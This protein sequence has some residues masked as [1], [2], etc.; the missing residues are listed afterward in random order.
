[1]NVCMTKLRLIIC[2]LL[3]H[4][5]LSAQTAMKS[6]L[7]SLLNDGLLD[8]VDASVVIYDLDED[9]L[10]YAHR[11]NKLVRP[12]SV[13]KV[14]TSAVA[15]EKLGSDYTIDT[16]L[17]ATGCDTALNLYVKG[18][19]DPL[20]GIDDISDMVAAVP[21]GSVVDT[22][23]ADCSFTDSLYWGSGWVWDDNPYGFQPY[24]S[25]LMVCGG[26]VEVVVSPTVKG[27]APQFKVTP[28][29]SFYSVVNEAVCNDPS[30]GKLTIL[31]DW[32]EDSNVIRIRGNCTKRYK[33]KINM[34]K[35]ADF[36][37]AL[38]AERLDSA[39]IEVRALSFG[40]VPPVSECIH[41]KHRQL[42]DVVNEALMES[43]NLC[44]E[45]LVYHLAAIGNESPL[46]MDEG[47]SV[48]RRFLTG[49]L[50]VKQSFS[51]AD[52]SGLSVYNYLSADML[53]RTLVRVRKNH[54]V[55]RVLYN[56]LPL[57]GVSGTMKNRTKGSAAYRKVRA[58]TGTVKG[59][60][61][62]AG[63]ARNSAGHLCAF[64]ILN[65]GLQKASLVREWQDRVLEVICKH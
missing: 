44:A 1:M 60:C 32:L 55:F 10:L 7:D 12:A 25:P 34:Y 54:R 61:T 62:L 38:L 18:R 30:L 50:D 42:A 26:S 58:K 22:I 45:A 63:Y 31:R 29:S 41:V 49:K 16:E 59:V 6:E 57:S 9:T 36:F 21:A 20:F 24:L 23:F 19:M 28:E 8:T 15:A 27:E 3:L 64:V 5:S 52:G 14:I 65:S 33:E 46:S 4:A 56:A 11:E 35:S 47:C 43:D 48:I 17:F 37:L 2:L 13:L 51:I 40:K 39:G 53:L